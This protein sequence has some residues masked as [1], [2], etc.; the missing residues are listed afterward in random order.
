MASRRRRSAGGRQSRLPRLGSGGRRFHSG[1]RQ[2]LGSRAAH[3]Q[4]LG[5]DIH[6]VRTLSRIRAVPLLSRLFGRLFRWPAFRIERRFAAHVAPPGAAVVPQLV[7]PA[8]P[9][10]LCDLS[11]GE[12]RMK[13]LILLMAAVTLR[14][15]PEIGARIP[16]FAAADQHGRQQ[17]FASLRGPKGLVLMF[18]R[19]AD[20]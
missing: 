19:S 3:W 7:P 11:G 1:G 18:V 13:G 16:D 14:T 6:R 15:G 2:P 5:M 12:E 4:W 8:L 17:T 9:V 10:P 20:W